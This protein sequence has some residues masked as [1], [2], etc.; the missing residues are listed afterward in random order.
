[1]VAAAGDAF[2]VISAYEGLELTLGDPE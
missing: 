1:V 2:E